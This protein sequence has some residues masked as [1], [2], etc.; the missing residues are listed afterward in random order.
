MTAASPS[1]SGGCPARIIGIDPGSLKTGVGVVDALAGDKLAHV[2][3]ATLAVGSDDFPTR[4]R[5][6]FE[7]VCA[8]IDEQQPTE[9]AIE[10]VFMARN[11]DSALK[12]GQARGAA[13]C[14]MVSRG[15]EV[16]EY[17]PTEVKRSIVGGGRAGK[18]QVQHM[19]KVLLRLQGPLQADAG[20]ALAIAI[21]HA[22]ARAGVAR[23]G[24]PR[25]AW[26]RRR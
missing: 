24:V 16:H 12:L 9:G 4:L 26:R 22:H 25:R 17:S 15:I 21:S 1:A 8:I 6:I 10:R 23:V 11:A 2:A 5:R 3:H 14:A 20:D 13:I 18:D 7:G 19:V